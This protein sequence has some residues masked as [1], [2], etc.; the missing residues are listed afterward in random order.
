[1][2]IP[3]VKYVL[4]GGGVASSAAVKAIRERDREGSALLVGQEV[5]RPYQR[6]SLN[7]EFLLGAKERAA[8]FT[9]PD[10]WFAEQQVELQTSRRATRLDMARQTVTLDSGDEIG[11]TKLLIATGGSPVHLKIPG[12]EMANVYYLRTLDDAERLCNAIEKA[13]QEG[14]PHASGRGRALVIGGGLLGV[15]LAGSLKQAGLGVDLVVP[16]AYPWA[17]F[18]GETAG[19]FIMR[20]LESQGVHLHLQ[21]VPLRLEGDGRVQRAVLS[22]GSTLEVDFVVPAIGI[23]PNKEILRGTP[24]AAEKAILTDDHCRTSHPDVYAAGDCAVVYDPLFGK[25]RW[26]DH[27]EAAMLMGH[28]AGANMAGGDERYAGVNHYSSGALGARLEVWGEWRHIERRIVRGNT[29]VENADFVEIGVASD[30]RVSQ[31][32]A[33]NHSG[34]DEVLRELVDRRL[35]VNGLESSLRDPANPVG[36]LLG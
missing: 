8:L 30:G 10:E 16:E 29:S 5:N 24:I 32:L 31:V 35:N 13:R 34:E 18:A 4:I 6:Q 15:E 1:M 25:H 22:T 9:V 2:N 11:F 26:I 33:V 19:R 28:V 20:Y 17:R 23:N 3:H 27:W 36:D 7:K 14:R 12:A 21:V